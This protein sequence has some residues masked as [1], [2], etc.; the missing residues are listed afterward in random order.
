V[1]VFAVTLLLI[2][3]LAGIAVKLLY[4]KAPRTAFA[5]ELGENI[6]TDPSFYIEGGQLALA[7]SEADFS[8]VDTGR[9]GV[10]PMT[11]RYL[12]IDY[13]FD[14]AIVDSIAPEIHVPEGPLYFMQGTELDT[15]DF[16]ESVTDADRDLDIRFNTDLMEKS[17][18]SCEFLGTYCAWLI[19]TDSSGNSSKCS[20]DFIVDLPPEI[21]E[22]GEFYYAIGSDDSILNYV[23]AYDQTD[24]DLSGR[25]TLSEDL[26][27]ITEPADMNLTLSVTDSCG[28][29]A[30]APVEVHVDTLDAIQNM[31]SEKEISRH[32]YQI[33]GAMNLYD[34]GIFHDQTMEETLVDVMPTVTDI[35]I[36][37]RNGS[38]TTGSGFIIQITDELIYIVTNEHVVND[39]SQCEIF[40]YTG[41][42]TFGK[43]V[44][45]DDDYDVAV[46]KVPLSNLPDGFEDSITTVHI[47]MT[48]WDTLR[49]E[50]IELGLE[51]LGRYGNIEH[52]T[53]G[54]LVRKLQSFAYFI[55]HIQTEMALKLHLGDSGSAVFDAEGRLIGM[56][57]AYSVSPERDWAVPLS[58]IVS[59]Y[60]EIT[61]NDL[62]TY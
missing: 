21:G 1:I 42:H 60:V 5:F 57:F 54:T 4:V 50:P 32:D 11:I 7:L 13:D 37:E 31:I 61:G 16:I 53:Y 59:A 41:D 46:I 2:C 29:T 22:V 26:R 24:G 15:S 14:I 40:F 8:K 62:Y 56:A 18:L 47:D 55:P 35:R 34:N 6:N 38:I 36:S 27:N 43:V 23:T 48:Y 45:V 17:S 20:V 58:E 3:V 30:T 25:I 9:P 12:W 28:F 51:K 19:A 10:Y 33:I 49:E 44:G 52:C 39:N